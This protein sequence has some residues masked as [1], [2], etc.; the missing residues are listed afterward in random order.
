MESIGRL[1]GGIA[2]DFNNL[3]SSI[4]GY[5]ELILLKLPAD[6][7]F[8]DY[9]LTVKEAGDKAALLTHR[10]L[11]FSRKQVLQM[12]VVNINTAVEN[13]VNMIGRMIREDI[14]LEVHT[15]PSIHS[16]MADPVQLEQV[17][18]NLIL[19]A[20]DA[21]PNGGKLIIETADF[22]VDHDFIIRHENV[23][24]GPYVMLTVSDTGIGMSK[25]IQGKLFE[26]FFTTKP[27]GEGTGL[28]LA[29]VYGVVKQHNGHIY[30][31]SEAG[32]GTTFKIFLPACNEGEVMTTQK[33]ALALVGGRETLLVVDDD[34]SIRK[35]MNDILLPLGYRLLFASDGEEA[36][37]LAKRQ[38]TSGYY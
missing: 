22:L 12:K 35:L 9:L 32:K 13:M 24:P 18:M 29:T 37:K 7:P 30:V 8:K 31:Y 20:R 36:M 10:L 2:H 3:L 23:K 19:N 28:G 5:T 1:A 11:A 33:E 21:M 14:V 6:S 15:E 27:M 26:P 17:L 34:P 25:Q 4:I 38:K 16:V